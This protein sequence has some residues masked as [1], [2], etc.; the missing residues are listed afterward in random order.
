MAYPRATNFQNMTSLW[1]GMGANGFTIWHF[2]N[3]FDDN[4]YNVQPGL[5]HTGSNANGNLNDSDA[6]LIQSLPA[7]DTQDGLGNYVQRTQNGTL[8]VDGILYADQ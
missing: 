3:L 4:N 8:S 5:P 6:S 2:T 7:Y 1:F